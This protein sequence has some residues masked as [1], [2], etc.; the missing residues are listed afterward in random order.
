ME[1][2]LGPSPF[3]RI[4]TEV[5]RIIFSFLTASGKKFTCFALHVQ[6]KTGFHNAI[7]LLQ[8]V[9]VSKEWNKVIDDDILWIHHCI[10]LLKSLENEKDTLWS[11]L[12]GR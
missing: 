1:N 5:K 12:V 11:R 3:D 2:D 7:D 4:P 8:C 6:Y 10:K 9:L